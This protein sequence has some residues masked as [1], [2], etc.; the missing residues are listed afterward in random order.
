MSVGFPVIYEPIVT[1]VSIVNGALTYMDATNHPVNLL[2]VVSVEK[3]DF[4]PQYTPVSLLPEDKLFNIQ[5]RFNGG[6]DVFWVFKT[7]AE[8]DADYAK[9]KE[10][11]LYGSSESG[12][13]GGLF[14]YPPI[15]KEFAEGETAAT[16]Q[17]DDLINKQI[18]F[19]RENEYQ[20][21]GVDFTFDRATGTITPSVGFNEFERLRITIT[22]I[23]A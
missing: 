7:E 15:I 6:S 10:A 9:L 14:F 1:N 22:A 20:T 4:V 13:G 19:E 5:L 2:N 16:F 11:K 17:H 21:E 18:A 12:D 3:G 23:L 8:R